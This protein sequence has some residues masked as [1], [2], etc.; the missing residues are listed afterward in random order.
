MSLAIQRDDSSI[1]VGTELHVCCKAIGKASKRNTVR[2]CSSSSLSKYSKL[3]T[4][5]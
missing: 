4:V 5:S 2:C 1:K 3:S